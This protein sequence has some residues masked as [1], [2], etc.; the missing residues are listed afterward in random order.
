MFAP[1][2]REEGVVPIESRRAP[3]GLLALPTAAA[4]ERTLAAGD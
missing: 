1:A 3:A 4:P 2:P